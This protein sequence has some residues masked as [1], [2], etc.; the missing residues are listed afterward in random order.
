MIDVKDL[1]KN[2]TDRVLFKQLHFSIQRGE[3]FGIIGPNGS[4]KSTLL[5]LLSGVDLEFSGE[6]QIKGKPIQGYKRKE[7]AKWLAVLQQ[8]ALPMLGFTVREVIE[9]GRYPFQNWLGEEAEDAGPKIDQIMETL[10][11]AWL[12]NEPL[13]QLSGGERQRV[14]L[15]KVMAQEPELLFLDEP[16]TFLDIGHQLQIMDYVSEWRDRAG[17]TV[18]AVLHDL[19]LAAQYCDRILM[20]HE[21]KIV[22]IGAPEQVITTDLIAQVY[23]TEPLIAPHPV[24]HRPQILLNPKINKATGGTAV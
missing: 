11:I 6:I 8:E 22:I 17:L 14:A 18:L 5:Q 15:A 10:G 2:F 24:N 4:G 9:M 16:T 23:G 1:S 20:L 19:N 3:F 21:G 7:L 13:E 12:A